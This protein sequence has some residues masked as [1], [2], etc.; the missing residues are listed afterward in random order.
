MSLTLTEVRQEMSGGLLVRKV[1]GNKVTEVDGTKLLRVRNQGRRVWP[2]VN[3]Q[4][5][6]S[7]ISSFKMT[8]QRDQ[9]CNVIPIDIV[10]WSVI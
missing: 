5:L 4:S 8:E 9:R 7:D 10:G 1:V 2:L 3:S 6:L